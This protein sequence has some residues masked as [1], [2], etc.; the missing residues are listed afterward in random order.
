MTQTNLYEKQQHEAS[1]DHS[2]YPRIRTWQDVI[3]NIMKLFLAHHFLKDIVKKPEMAQ[4]WSNNP[5][6]ET[7]IFKKRMSRNCFRSILHFLH[8]SD[9]ANCNTND[10]NCDRLVKVRPLVIHLVIRF[11]RAY[12]LTKENYIDE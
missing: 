5:L 10:P 9:N 8:F 1:A 7:P 2:T 11:K 12:T 6:I 3:V 4:Y